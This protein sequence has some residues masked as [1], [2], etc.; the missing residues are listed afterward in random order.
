MGSRTLALFALV[1]AST[2]AAPA[3]L[4]PGMLAVSERGEGAMRGITIGP[5]E[6]AL[7]PNKGY[8]S[9][10]YRRMLREAR[11]LGPGG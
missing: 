10:A 3:P 7:H 2:L 4:A 9:D 6:N 11:R 5:I 8:G 1:S